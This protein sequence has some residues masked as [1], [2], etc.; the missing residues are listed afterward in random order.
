MENK[1]P[2]GTFIWSK[3]DPDCK[4]V[5]NRYYKRIYYCRAVVNP[6]E[7]PLAYFERELMFTGSSR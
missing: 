7:K 1:Y 6:S 3:R 2:E 5:I 4:L